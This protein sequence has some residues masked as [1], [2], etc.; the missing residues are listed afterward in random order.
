MDGVHDIDCSRAEILVVDDTRTNLEIMAAI[1]REEGYG[2]TLAPDGKK[3][4]ELAPELEPDLILL[5]V[6]MP[7]IDGFETCRRL[8]AMES[9]R[10]I[11]VIFVTTRTQQEHIVEGFDAGAID[12]IGKPIQPAEVCARVRAH[13][14]NQFLLKLIKDYEARHRCIINEVSDALITLVPPGTIESANPAALFLFGYSLRSMIGMPLTELMLPEY[15]SLCERFF[16]EEA[17][18]ESGEE[19]HGLAPV[20]VVGQRRDGS[21]VPLDFSIQRLSLS[22]PLYVCLMHDLT[23]HKNIINE[24]QRV[25]N[26]D[27]L[28]NIANRRRFETVFEREWLQAAKR[29]TSLS[30][31]LLDIDYFKTYND[32]YG[33]RAGDSCLQEVARAIAD[34][35]THRSDLAARYGGEEFVLV[36]ADT[37]GKGARTVAEN[38]LRRVAE[39]EIPHAESMARDVV[40]VSAGV[41]TVRPRDG[42][43]PEGLVDAADQ[44]LYQAKS[45]GRNRIEVAAET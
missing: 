29:G 3:A 27:R 23:I 11:P 35:V 36:L 39:L 12:Y 38:A 14:R 43:S 15:H 41:A 42:G 22:E 30:L 19:T 33:H 20:E 1:L 31:V 25:S 2:V 17:D 28:T 40:T 37:D 34:S 16:A 26:L 18:R 10:E 7:G 32:Q 6:M 24:L 44:A 8:K 9:T 13:V 5:D 4:L 21:T 45:A